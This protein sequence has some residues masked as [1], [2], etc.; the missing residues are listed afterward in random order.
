M[1][2]RLRPATQPAVQDFLP[3]R[4][5]DH[6]EF[7]VGNAHQAAHFYQ[8][9][10]GFQL[11]AYAGPETGVRDR[12]SYA[13]TQGNAT[14]VLTAGLRPDS[15][16]AQHVARHGDGVRD[17]ALRVDDVDAAFRHTTDRGAKAMLDPVTIAGEKGAIR[18]ATIATYGDTV[19]SFIN[20]EGYTGAF[21]PLYHR[22]SRPKH[23][24]QAPPTVGAG[25]EAID[26]I[27]G[28]VELGQMDRWASFY[29][30]V[31]GFNQLVHFTDEAIS[32]EYTALMSKVMQDGAGRI[33]FPINEP[34]PGKRR[35]QIDEYLE[36]Y[37]GPGVQH[38]ALHSRDIIQ[39]VR[40]LREGGVQFLRA[41]DTYYESL[42]ERLGPIQED[43]DTIRELQIL[44]DRDDEGYLLQ[45]FTR[46]VQDRPTLFFEII[47]R[48]GATGFG[49]GNFKALFEAIEAEQ[50]R[51]GNL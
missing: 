39:T 38:I 14:F 37:G 47:Q 9:A 29:R 3:I 18:R 40:A 7:W 46:P 51:R 43:F 44:A 5:I 28:N 13:L 23:G 21:Y 42:R 1:T 41:P 4:A 17:I 49:A 19:H 25:I 33:K 45:I 34:A 11:L 22:R 32:T 16:I 30:D 20:R 2:V 8:K 31:M 27:V 50:R 36:F 35:S 24:E 6:V 12:A 26:H 10:F 48:R 15:P